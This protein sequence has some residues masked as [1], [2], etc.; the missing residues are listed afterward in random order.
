M[1]VRTLHRHLQKEGTSYQFLKDEFRKETALA[2]I[3]RR[4]LKINTIAL[5]MGFQDSSA[6]HRSF[7]KWTGLSPGQYRRQLDKAQ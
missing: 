6:F 1:S 7:K 2:Y 3:K 5:L 4:E